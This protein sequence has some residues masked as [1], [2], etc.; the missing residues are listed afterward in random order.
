M[1][2]WDDNGEFVWAAD[3]NGMHRRCSHRARAARLKRRSHSIARGCWRSQH[4]KDEA[5]GKAWEYLP[6]STSPPT[7]LVNL[8][9]PGQYLDRE[10]GL[11][12]NW[13]RY[14]DPNTGRYLT[15]D[16]LSQDMDVV[17][18][19]IHV[20]DALESYSYAASNPLLNVDADGQLVASAICAA[21]IFKQNL[22]KRSLGDPTDDPR[23]WHCRTSCEIQT[24][25]NLDFP[26]SGHVVASSAGVGWEL[27]QLPGNTA[28]LGGVGPAVSDALDDELDNLRGL[29]PTNFDCHERCKECP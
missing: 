22:E 20:G 10:T 12:Y 11:H 29:L 19:L 13:H 14:Y 8:R 1:R 4:R 25:C 23:Y 27:N 6:E 17:S 18:A 7:V 16:P 26:G 28:D 9:F 3:T 24:Y 15:P 2:A 21:V 5:F